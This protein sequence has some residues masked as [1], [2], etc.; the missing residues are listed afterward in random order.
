[1]LCVCVCVKQAGGGAH[2]MG[3]VPGE[4]T[5][6]VHHLPAHPGHGDVHPGT[7]LRHRQTSLLWTQEHLCPGSVSTH[8]RTGHTHAHTGHT[9]T[10]ARTHT[11]HTNHQCELRVN[12]TLY[13]SLLW[14]VCLLSRVVILNCSQDPEGSTAAGGSC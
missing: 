13:S 14:F 7:S 9:H 6:G 11:G 3:R 2:H 4:G 8:T 1:M 5:D 12:K 10:H